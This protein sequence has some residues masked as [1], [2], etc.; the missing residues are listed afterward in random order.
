MFILEA[1]S[2]LLFISNGFTLYYYH[3]KLKDLKKE[4]PLDKDATELLKDL[5]NGNAIT[6]VKV[7]DPQSIYLWSARD[8]QR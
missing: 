2:A 3:T 7:I 8:I 4:R 5:I 1:I 6:V